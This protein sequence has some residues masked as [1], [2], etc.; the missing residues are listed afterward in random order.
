[1]SDQIP[2]TISRYFELDRQRDLEEM[3]ALFTEDATVTD[4][5]QTMHGRDAIRAWREGT[6]SKYTYTTER[7]GTET[8]APSRYLV[9]AR[10]TGDFPGGTVDLRWDFTIEDGRIKNLVIAP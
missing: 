6:A 8:V 5:G 7:T 1:V 10:L 3:L 2:E 9:L 4:E